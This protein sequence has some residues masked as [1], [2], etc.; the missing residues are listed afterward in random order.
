M[1]PTIDEVSATSRGVY[2]NTILAFS[3]GGPDGQAVA[4]DPDTLA[5]FEREMSLARG[6]APSLHLSVG[7]KSGDLTATESE[8]RRLERRIESR[9]VAFFS[10]LGDFWGV[11]ITQRSKVQI[12]PPQPRFFGA[13]SWLSAFQFLDL[14]DR[15]VNPGSAASSRSRRRVDPAS[16][17]LPSDPEVF[18]VDDRVALADGD[19]PRDFWP[20][21]AIDLVVEERQ[22]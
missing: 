7:R 5:R 2:S 16:K 17:P 12:L 3:G 1:R 11:L 10:T 21:E 13:D 9:F 14:R 15:G 8:N 19:Q 4:A 22:E 6:Q 18:V 20:G